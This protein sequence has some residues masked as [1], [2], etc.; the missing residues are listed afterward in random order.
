MRRRCRGRRSLW[1]RIAT[2]GELLLCRSSGSNDV[3][4]TGSTA[5]CKNRSDSSTRSLTAHSGSS[6]SSASSSLGPTSLLLLVW[7]ETEDASRTTLA[8]S[9]VKRMMYINNNREGKGNERI[10][11]L[12]FQQQQRHNIGMV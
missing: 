4:S 7:A 1:E 8:K 3:S 10:T 6:A 12:T 9:A 11:T 5:G 2:E